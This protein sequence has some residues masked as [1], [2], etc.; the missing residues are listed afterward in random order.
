LSNIIPPWREHSSNIS[1]T[2]AQPV[3]D[4][5]GWQGEFLIK[6]PHRKLQAHGNAINQW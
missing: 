6:P 5:Y 1:V 2:L 3:P 4:Q